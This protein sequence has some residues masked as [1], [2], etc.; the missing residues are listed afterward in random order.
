MWMTGLEVIVAALVAGA[1]SGTVSGASNVAGAAIGDAY[2]S[3]RDALR[4]RLAG[5]RAA[6]E[7]D[8]EPTDDPDV[9]QA[10]IGPDVTDSGADHDEEILTAARTLLELTDPEGA[11]AGRYTVENRAVRIGTSSAHAGTVY[12]PTAGTMTGSVTVSYGQLPVPPAP[13]AAT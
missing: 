9:W 13:P 3:L 8:A 7:I 1:L 10:R 12:G 5:R 6:N 4:R 11:K 2:T